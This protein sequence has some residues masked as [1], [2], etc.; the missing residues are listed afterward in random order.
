M[1]IIKRILV[2]FFELMRYASSATTPHR[3][4]QNQM[5]AYDGNFKL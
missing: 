5:F 1:E 3:S 2:H 4:E